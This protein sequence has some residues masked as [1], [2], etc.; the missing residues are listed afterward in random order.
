ME[1]GA[2]IENLCPVENCILKISNSANCG[3]LQT[4]QLYIL[5]TEKQAGVFVELKFP[6]NSMQAQAYSTLEGTG[7]GYQIS[8]IQARSNVF[9]VFELRK[10]R[11]AKN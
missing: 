4:L 2:L 10:T 11:H 6:E 7:A 8:S 5:K 3:K 9:Q 1:A